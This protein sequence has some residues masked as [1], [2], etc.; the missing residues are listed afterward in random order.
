MSRVKVS[1]AVDVPVGASMEQVTAWLRFECHDT[2]SINIKNPLFRKT[3][4][5]V[6]GTF[7]VEPPWGWAT[8]KNE[9]EGGTQ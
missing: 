4:Y 9:A 6:D 7:E 2:S 1:F 8:P 5:P 3:M